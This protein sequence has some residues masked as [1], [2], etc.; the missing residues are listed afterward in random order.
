[1]KGSI[2]DAVKDLVVD[3]FGSKMWEDILEGAGLDRFTTVRLLDDVPDE[4]VMK[5]LEVAMDKLNLSFDELAD[6]FGEY[7]I[8]VYVP[9]V[10]KPY[11]RRIKSAKVLLL[12]LDDIH[13]K[14]VR[15]IPN[16]NPPRFDYRWESPDVLIMKYKSPRNLVRVFVGIVK[17]LGNK[18]GEFV[19]V[20]MLSNNE[21]RIRFRGE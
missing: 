8:N 16:A 6:V 18:Y 3:N 15:N 9:K 1:M 7:W 4:V 5:V 14:V 13:Q 12:K 2:V 19:D 21:V 20:T 11:L 17:A 10:Y